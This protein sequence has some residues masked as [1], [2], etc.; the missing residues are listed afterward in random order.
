[1]RYL[2]E[3]SYARKAML[4]EFVDVVVSV[5]LLP[6]PQLALQSSKESG[7]FKGSNDDTVEYEIVASTEWLVVGQS[8]R[9]FTMKVWWHS[10]CGVVLIVEQPGQVQAFTFQLLPMACGFLPLPQVRLIG[11][12]VCAMH[13]AQQIYVYPPTLFHSFCVENPLIE[14]DL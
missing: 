8:K 14:E 13:D 5:T 1:V 10:F 11:V 3:F 9:T 2:L 7:Q 6:R 4:G 12:E